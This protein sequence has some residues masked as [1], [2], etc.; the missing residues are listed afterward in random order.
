MND[1]K[2]I[3][4]KLKEIRIEKDLKLD[5]VA[6][7]SGNTTSAISK[8]ENNGL[9]DLE[10][11]AILCDVL[12]VDIKKVIFSDFEEVEVEK[13][14]QNSF[15][16]YKGR[17]YD[18]IPATKN[19][20]G[21]LKRI[22]S[23]ININKNIFYFAQDA[24][25]LNY[26]YDDLEKRG[27]NIYVINF[28]DPSSSH[29][30]DPISNL[31]DEKDISKFADFLVDLFHLEPATSLILTS[32]ISYLKNCCSID[33]QNLFCLL[34]LIREY[35]E[36]FGEHE[37]NGVPSFFKNPGYNLNNFSILSLYHNFEMMD[38]TRKSEILTNLTSALSFVDVMAGPYFRQLEYNPIPL[39]NS[40]EKTI[41]FVNKSPDDIFK[42]LFDMLVYQIKTVLWKDSETNIQ[43]KTELNEEI[44]EKLFSKK[45]P[46]KMQQ[47]QER[48]LER[49]AENDVKYA[50]RMEKIKVLLDLDIKESEYKLYPL[51]FIWNSIKELSEEEKEKMA[52][53]FLSQ[54]DE[55]LFKKHISAI[56][57][58][59][60]NVGR[61][62]EF[63]LYDTL[64]PAE[65][66]KIFA[67]RKYSALQMAVAKF[68]L[69]VGHL[70]EEEVKAYLDFDYEKIYSKDVS[71]K[72]NVS[73][74]TKLTNSELINQDIRLRGSFRSEEAETIRLAK[75]TV[76]EYFP[77]LASLLSYKGFDI[78]KYFEENFN[79]DTIFNVQKLRLLYYYYYYDIE[80]EDYI[81]HLN[82]T[83]AIIS[84][85]TFKANRRN[86][87]QYNYL[88]SLLETSGDFINTEYMPVIFNANMPIGRRVLFAHCLTK[89]SG[90]E[91]Y[92]TWDRGE[93]KLVPIGK[94]HY[95]KVKK[96]IFELL[97]NS[98]FPPTWS[99]IIVEGV[100]RKIDEDV[101]VKCCNIF[102]PNDLRKVLKIYN[103][104]LIGIPFEKIKP[105]MNPVFTVDQ[106]EA[107]ICA[108]EIDADITPYI[109]AALISNWSLNSNDPS[110]IKQKWSTAK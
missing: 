105:I 103:A 7:M 100:I 43:E 10:K 98:S 101:I 50:D 32:F 69:Y 4:Q 38:D 5:Y 107:M 3:G 92:R 34:S 73:E 53:S 81:K 12:D 108:L 39:N 44:S 18:L 96:I 84:E 78:N 45:H 9:K 58:I 17:R 48:L 110:G 47:L 2:T 99:D 91:D 16:N 42:P 59:A 109:N 90:V 55:I 106:L 75:R 52:S 41:I 23:D 57:R 102:T 71:I 82:Q 95:E 8:Y 1:A 40:M 93:Q 21:D 31:E 62:E 14:D 20:T 68:D 30:Y 46:S 37:T 67:D 28:D 49:S 83:P 36:S 22:K 63:N 64:L 11:I 85:K 74:Y 56:K 86:L 24:Q 89:I 6:R 76:E 97:P 72:G 19:A 26:V 70:S 27:Y 51:A 80:P 94:D 25:M 15:S 87:Y 104:I 33:Q 79:D 77:L 65:K 60:K 88:S 29:L 35:G 54:R 66:V 13:N 61:I